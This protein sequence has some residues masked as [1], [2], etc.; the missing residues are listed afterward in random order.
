MAI[1]WDVPEISRKDRDYLR[2]R[3]RWLGFKELQKSL[4]VFPFN[5][6]NEVKELIKFYKKDL[7]GDVRFLTIEKIEN[8]SDLRK[9]F[10]L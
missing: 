9:Y 10:K 4:W 1:C 7:A 8:D 6:E 5:I 3:L 2:N